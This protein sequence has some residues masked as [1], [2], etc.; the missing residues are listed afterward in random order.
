MVN[1]IAVGDIMPGGILTVTGNE[2]ASENVRGI[3]AKADLRVGNFECAV[4]VP[5]PKGK[6]IELGGNTV[7]VKERDVERVKSLGIDVVSIA[8]NHLFDLGIEGARK[9]IE[10]LDNLGIRHCGAGMN[11]AEARKP[12]IIKIGEKVISFLGYSQSTLAARTTY[13]ATDTE[14]GVC[15]LVEDIYTEDIRIARENSDYVVV[16]PHWG[17]ENTYYPTL[18]VVQLSR[19]LV[20]AG[21]DIILGGHSHRIQPIINYRKSVIVYSMGNFLFPN[22]IIVPPKFT[23]YPEDEI[24]LDSLPTT[25]GIPIVK[26]PTIKCW[27]PLAYIGSMVKVCLDDKYIKTHYVLTLA[28][29]NGFVKLLDKHEKRY[30]L[31]LKY[32]GLSLKINLYPIVYKIHHRLTIPISKRINK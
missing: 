24:D 10:T 14:P 5:H 26:Q 12:V 20:D 19:K 2:Y 18:E 15:P 22:R 11:L 6:K 16:I 13:F 30:R 31:I 32:I 17:T 29:K 9:A 23:W 25:I 3:L 7:F 1:I 28:H 8:N 4:A 21:A 27:R